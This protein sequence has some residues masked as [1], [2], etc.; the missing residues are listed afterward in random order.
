MRGAGGRAGQKGS[1]NASP[2]RRR[3]G[4]HVRPRG[5]EP[6]GLHRK[7][8][9]QEAVSSPRTVSSRLL[10]PNQR[11]QTDPSLRLS[12]RLLMRAAVVSSLAGVSGCTSV[13]G[14]SEADQL[15]EHYQDGYSR[16]KT[17]AEKHNDAV[18]AYR[19]D[20]YEHVQQLITNAIDQLRQARTAFESAHDLATDLDDPDVRRIVSSALEKSR[21]LI[22]ASKLLQETAAGFSNEEYEAAQE[23]YEDYREK[24][25]TLQETE[26]MAPARLAE[27]VD[28]GLL[29]L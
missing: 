27:R 13:L 9:L 28:T 20:E 3:W 8:R 25:R 17:G 12:R 23:R 18:I 24:S 2:V 14:K 16:Y 19:S 26:M 6:N 15:L 10:Q 29:D 11:G 7:R 22:E 5:S 21:L 4:F 1:G